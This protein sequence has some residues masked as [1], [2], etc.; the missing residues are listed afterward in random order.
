LCKLYIKL[1]EVSGGRSLSLLSVCVKEGFDRSEKA[2]LRT[3]MIGIIN[4]R[5]V[6]REYEALAEHMPSAS[7]VEDFTDIQNRLD[8]AKAIKLVI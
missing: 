7:S 3:G 2:V 8:T 4:R 6:H 1:R 5:A